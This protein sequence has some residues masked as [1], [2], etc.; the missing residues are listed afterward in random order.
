[1]TTF[2]FTAN[3]LTIVAGLVNT[4]APRDK[5]TEEGSYSFFDGGLAAGFESGTWADCIIDETGEA[6]VFRG[7]I[8]SLIKKDFF[9]SSRDEDGVWLMLTEAAVEEI[10]ARIAAL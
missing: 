4:F 3:E 8:S 10:T 7:V 6:K 9:E 5:R 1:M 2:N